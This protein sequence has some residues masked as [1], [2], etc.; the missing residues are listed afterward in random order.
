[1]LNLLQ[2]FLA[3]F[4]DLVLVL[5][6]AKVGRE[7][8]RLHLSILYFQVVLSSRFGFASFPANFDFCRQRPQKKE[9]KSAERWNH[10]RVEMLVCSLL[11]STV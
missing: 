11:H 7:G 9:K 1:L 2:Q 6:R 3:Q 8:N 10:R 4:Q 5:Q